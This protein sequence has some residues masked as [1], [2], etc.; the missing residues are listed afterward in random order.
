MESP[1]KRTT[2]DW[3][4]EVLSFLGLIATCIPLF[5]YDSL[6]DKELVPVHFN[7]YGEADGWGNRSDLWILPSLAL[8]FY[9]GFFLFERCYT[10]FNYPL[11]ITERNA[12]LIYRLGVRLMRHSKLIAIFL[13]ADCNISSFVIATGKSTRMTP[14][15]TMTLLLALFVTIF[16]YVIRMIRLREAN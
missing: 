1:L 8:F 15:I 2:Y 14:F 9:L 4:I 16:F 7:L 12:N 3:S 6:G 10:K 11:K 5:F 13:F